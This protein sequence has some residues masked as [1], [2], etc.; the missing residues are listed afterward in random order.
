VNL[1]RNKYKP[2]YSMERSRWGKNRLDLI[3]ENLIDLIDNAI[4]SEKQ[5]ANNI[6]ILDERTKPKMWIND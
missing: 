6:R 4:L 5:T 2:P 3:E 1:K